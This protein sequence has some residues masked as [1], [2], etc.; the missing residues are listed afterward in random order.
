MPWHRGATS[1]QSQ[2]GILLFA[3]QP[4]LVSIDHCSLKL[5]CSVYSYALVIS[6]QGFGGESS[7]NASC[8]V[9]PSPA[10]ECLCNPLCNPAGASIAQRDSAPKG[11]QHSTSKIAQGS[12]RPYWNSPRFCLKT[13]TWP[14]LCK[15]PMKN[16]C[17]TYFLQHMSL[18]G[19]NL[20]ASFG[21]SGN[22]DWSLGFLSL[23]G[24][25]EPSRRNSKG[26]C[27]LIV[28]HLGPG[29]STPQWGGE[30]NAALVCWRSGGRGTSEN[31]TWLSGS[32][33]VGVSGER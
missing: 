10:L 3:E 7:G 18:Q 26:T 20:Y 2:T 13:Q 19:S 15:S 21:T 32:T 27:V 11:S 22:W 23:C 17:A 33:P 25:P 1:W 8:Q 5:V 30:A 16:Y 6:Q 4:M 9:F 28:I 12:V 14:S 24:T 29:I 31:M